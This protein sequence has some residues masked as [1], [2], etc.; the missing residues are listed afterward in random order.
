[1]SQ[2]LLLQLGSVGKGLLIGALDSGL[3]EIPLILTLRGVDEGTTV[4][5]E[6]QVTLL[7]RSIGDPLRG[8]VL[9]IGDI[10]IAMDDKG[11][12][13]I[14]RRELGLRRACPVSLEE[15]LL[16]AVV[17]N[18]LHRK[19]LRLSTFGHVVEPTI[20][21]EGDVTTIV[22]REIADRVLLKVGQLS[23]VGRVSESGAVDIK[24]AVPLAQEEESLLAREPD[25]I[26]ILALEGSD[27]SKLAHVAIRSPHPY[28]SGDGRLVVLAQRI[29]V[30]LEVGKEDPP[31]GAI[32]RRHLH[33]KCREEVRPSAVSLDPVDL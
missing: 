28:I 11:V 27:L 8:A 13:L 25:G 30:P 15:L 29:L 7:L 31:V 24:V 9:D 4:G 22:H 10:D 1:M 26:A 6:G 17:G 5:A 21:G 14:I 18:H 2:L 32:D 20:P 23:G 19:L 3:V 16:L 12:L 33:R